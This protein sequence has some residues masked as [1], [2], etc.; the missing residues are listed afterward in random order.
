[1]N[2]ANNQFPQ[3][4]GRAL[5][6]ANKRKDDSVFDEFTECKSFPWD[7]KVEW[8]MDTDAGKA[9]LGSPNGRGVGYLL[10]QHKSTFGAATTV[11]KVTF[12][13]TGDPRFFLVPNLVFHITR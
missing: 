10:A 8:N 4:I 1:M 13:C 5:H 12:F 11:N 9:L 7:S 2:I 6:E 3:I